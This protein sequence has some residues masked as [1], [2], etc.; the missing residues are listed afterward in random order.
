MRAGIVYARTTSEAKWIHAGLFF[1]YFCCVHRKVPRTRQPECAPSEERNESENVLVAAL[2]QQI[3]RSSPWWTLRVCVRVFAFLLLIGRELVEWHPR[4][5]WRWWWY[6]HGRS[7]LRIEKDN[8]NTL[9]A[10]CNRSLARSCILAVCAY[11]GY[12]CVV[13][14]ISTVAHHRTQQ[15]RRR[16][17]RRRQR[18]KCWA[19][20]RF[21]IDIR[22]FD[23]R[24]RRPASTLSSSEI[25]VIV[26]NVLS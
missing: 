23:P 22:P 18:Q 17:R 26:Y 11:S 9:P 2:V 21:Q 13:V 1:L 24:R 3:M 8:N 14:F 6:T 7:L 25:I 10:Y 15:Q 19:K 5:R 16:R 12:V 20:K 4:H